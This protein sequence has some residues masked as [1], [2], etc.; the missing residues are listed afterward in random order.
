MALIDEKVLSEYWD[1]ARSPTHESVVRHPYSDKVGV[2]TIGAGINLSLPGDRKKFFDTFG[3]SLIHEPRKSASCRVLQGVESDPV[4]LGRDG[5]AVS[6]EEFY[7]L[8]DG[9]AKIAEPLKGDTPTGKANPAKYQEGCS[10]VRI[11]EA[12]ADEIARQALYAKARELY[13]Y[14]LNLSIKG[15]KGV[16]KPNPYKQLNEF[17]VPAQL[18]IL[19]LLFNGGQ[20]D[21]AH[22]TV[23]NDAVVARDW[24]AA[25]AD[26]VSKDKA[27]RE[28]NP[29]RTKW[30]RTKLDEAAAVKKPLPNG[31]DTNPPPT[32]A[33]LVPESR[34]HSHAFKNVLNV[35]KQ[36]EQQSKLAETSRDALLQKRGVPSAPGK[37]PRKLA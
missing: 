32:A 17:P 6:R 37:L 23:F 35:W 2:V 28:L 36:R 34:K 22:R 29:T 10:S 7:A 18:V 1:V 31:V 24:I 21:V 14:L 26:V 19:D 3:P 33:D 5:S 9:L 20:G 4:S 11:K 12:M 16:I 27:R 13:G 30:R 15:S 25:K 8:L